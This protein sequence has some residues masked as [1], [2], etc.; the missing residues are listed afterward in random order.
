MSQ[1]RLEVLETFLRGF[2]PYMTAALHSQSVCQLHTPKVLCWTE[3]CSE[4]H[5]KMVT[6]FIK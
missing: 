4:L 1:H 6:V 2:A 5:L 3:V